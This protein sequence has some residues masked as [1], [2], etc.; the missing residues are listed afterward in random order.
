MGFGHQT[1]GSHTE[2]L[3]PLGHRVIQNELKI[4]EKVIWI[5]SR[6]KRHPQMESSCRV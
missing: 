3:Y 2:L 6:V 4:F 1:S 5:F